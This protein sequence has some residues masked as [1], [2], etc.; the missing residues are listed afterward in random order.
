[1]RFALQPRGKRAKCDTAVRHPQLLGLADF[2]K[3]PAEGRA[4]EDRVVTKTAGAVG[5][6]RDLTLDNSSGFVD[7]LAVVDA[8]QR[9]NKARGPGFLRALVQPSE[10]L[11]EPLWI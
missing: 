4:I 5:R 10:D 7:H 8:G 6:I 9:A 2:R 11:F 3:G 1:M